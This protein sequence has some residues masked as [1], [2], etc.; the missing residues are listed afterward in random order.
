MAQDTLSVIREELRE[1]LSKTNEQ[2]G[3]I[4]KELEVLNRARQLK[5]YDPALSSVAGTLRDINHNLEALVV[6]VREKR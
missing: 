6:L 3:E 4:G 5:P 1:A 2:L